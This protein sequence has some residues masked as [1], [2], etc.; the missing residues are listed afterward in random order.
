MKTKKNAN[1]A[2]DEQE[3]LLAMASPVFK[4]EKW[5]GLSC[6]PAKPLAHISKEAWAAIEAKELEAFM[7]GAIESPTEKHAR[8]REAFEKSIAREDAQEQL[9]ALDAERA[10]LRKQLQALEG[11]PLSPEKPRK[12]NQ[13]RHSTL[14][15]AGKSLRATLGDMIAQ[16][17]DKKSLETF[18]YRTL[19]SERHNE[20]LAAMPEKQAEAWLKAMARRHA[21]VAIDVS[22]NGKRTDVP[23]SK[24][25]RKTIEITGE[26]IKAILEKPLAGHIELGMPLDIYAKAHAIVTEYKAQGIIA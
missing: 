21:A 24:G 1:L 17:H 2:I 22:H 5:Q 8:A 9:Q 23:K 11:K 6:Y 18:A 7:T 26:Q 20:R 12:G 14:S 25:S 15:I 16:G 10:F 13:G 4:T 3:A 19:K